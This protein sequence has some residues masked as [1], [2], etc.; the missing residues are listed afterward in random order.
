MTTIIELLKDEN[1][2]ARVSIGWRWLVWDDAWEVY[3]RRYGARKTT[4]V[5]T[6]ESETEAVAA[7]LEDD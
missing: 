5:L 6:T 7:L 3:E 2:M 1:L 4:L